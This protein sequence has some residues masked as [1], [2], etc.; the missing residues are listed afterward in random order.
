L[1]RA[2]RK[3]VQMKTTTLALLLSTAIAAPA[4]AQSSTAPAAPAAPAT[5]MA[6]PAAGAT[7]GGGFITEQAEDQWR[8]SELIGTN[9]YGPDDASIGEI[10]DVLVGRDGQVDVAIVGVGGFLGIGQKD[11]GIP[12]DS[13]EWRFSADMAN[14]TAATGTNAPATAPAAPATGTGAG[15]TATDPA[16][17]TAD[18][19]ANREQ[20][21]D[22]AYVSYTREDLNNAPAFVEIDDETNTA[23]PPPAGE[24][25][26]ATAPAKP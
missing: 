9:V 25:A 17:A 1:V 23:N 14:N 21:P 15:T 13:I 22:R 19:A 4:F 26:P 7:A 24:T 18:P 11:V 6:A 20:S 3:E 12:F 8:A 5:E 2:I 16:P 10:S